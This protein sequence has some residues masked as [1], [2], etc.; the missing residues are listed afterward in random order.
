M[1]QNDKIEKL[2]SH[3]AILQNSVSLLKQEQEQEKSEQYSR[4]LCL[5]IEGIKPMETETADDC[6]EKVKD[7]FTSLNVKIPNEVIDRAH[8]IGKPFKNIN[9]KVIHPVIVRFTTW[10]HR[11]E[12]YQA[13]IK[14]KSAKYKI[15]LDLTKPRYIYH[16]KRST[17]FYMERWEVYRDCKFC[18]CRFELSIGRKIEKHI[19]YYICRFI[20]YRSIMPTLCFN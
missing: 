7:V 6:M 13:R 10:R 16:F 8:R 18:I 17:K 14:S 4:R 19:T 11:T 5:C 1:L 12:V 2:E 9:G 15:R 3:V 20:K